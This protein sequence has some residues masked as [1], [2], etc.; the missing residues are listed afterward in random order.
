[1]IFTDFQTSGPHYRIVISVNVVVALVY[2]QTHHQE[3]SGSLHLL[4]GIQHASV[5]EAKL[6]ST[7]ARTG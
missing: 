7:A 5:S 4:I 3:K 2:L 1:M 6:F